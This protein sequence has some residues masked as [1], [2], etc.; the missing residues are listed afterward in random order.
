MVIRLLP[1]QVIPRDELKIASLT[2]PCWNCG[3][4]QCVDVV[5]HDGQSVRRD[6]ANCGQT[7]DFSKWHGEDR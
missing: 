7:W 5:I 3:H 6:C 1:L 4:T 2:G